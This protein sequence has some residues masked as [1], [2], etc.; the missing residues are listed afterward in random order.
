MCGRTIT[1]GFV[2]ADHPGVIV[3]RLESKCR[4]RLFVGNLL[5]I[6]CQIGWKV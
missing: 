2:L 6:P 3:W 5:I 4:A 1:S